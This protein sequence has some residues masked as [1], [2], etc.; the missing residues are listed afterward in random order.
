MQTFGDSKT[1]TDRLLS[2]L[3]NLLQMK[4]A[5]APVT[6]E[7]TVLGVNYTYLCYAGANDIANTDAKWLV[8]QIAEDT[9]T[10]LTT[11]RWSSASKSFD[12]AIEGAGGVIATITALTYYISS[13]VIN[14]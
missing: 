9:A 4:L 14:K 5:V 6:Y 10:N 7:V 1:G 11:S 2:N 3:Y 8:L 12:V 13:S